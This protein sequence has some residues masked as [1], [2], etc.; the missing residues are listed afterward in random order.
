MT[1]NIPAWFNGLLDNHRR[2]LPHRNRQ[3]AQNPDGNCPVLRYDP[4]GEIS[5]H[6]DSDLFQPTAH[7]VLAPVPSWASLALDTVRRVQDHF[8]AGGLD[9]G[10]AAFLDPYLTALGVQHHQSAERTYL[11]QVDTIRHLYAQ[12]EATAAKHRSRLAAL[13]DAICAA[14]DDYADARDHLL[15]AKKTPRWSQ[16][17]APGPVLPATAPVPGTAQRLRTRTPGAAAGPKPAAPVLPP[18]IT[19]PVGP[20]ADPARNGATGHTPGPDHQWS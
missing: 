1:W 11:V 10:T 7:P 12:E 16:R 3:T 8:D 9:A 4:D 15:G 6:Y 14:D 13:E 19:L 2:R 17:R 18:S 20:A 5:R